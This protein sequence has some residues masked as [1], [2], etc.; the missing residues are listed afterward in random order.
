MH[1]RT[2]LAALA[3][4]VCL[5]VWGGSVFLVLM[6]LSCTSV[7]VPT[8]QDV[9]P[10]TAPR[11]VLEPGEALGFEPEP[12]GMP[13]PDPKLLL[14]IAPIDEETGEPVEVSVTVPLD[15]RVLGTGLREYTFELPGRMAEPREL[16]VEAEGYERWSLFLRYKLTNTRKWDIPIKL[17]PL[18]LVPATPEDA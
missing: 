5:F 9:A 12:V 10:L 2:K 14:H 3:L 15:A 8:T 16:A 7:I 6:S 13:E 1:S 17:V 18:S 4:I 11:A